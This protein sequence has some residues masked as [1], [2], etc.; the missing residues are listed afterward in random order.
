MRQIIPIAR[1]G[2][3]VAKLWR[4][5]S[6][7]GEQ[8]AAAALMVM[9]ALARVSNHAGPRCI[10]RSNC[11][12]TGHANGARPTTGWREATGGAGGRMLTRVHVIGP[13]REGARWCPPH[14]KLVIFGR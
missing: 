8:N 11:K 1:C 5:V 9:S 4:Q 7:D 3:I 6:K 2:D 14:P 10:P 13:E 12:P